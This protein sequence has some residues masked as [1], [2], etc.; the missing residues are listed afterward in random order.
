MKVLK[1]LGLVL[2]G[3]L[4]IVIVLGLIAPKDFRVERSIVIPTSNKEVIYKNISTWSDFLKW[5]PW[6]GKDPNQK[7]TYAGTEATVG[8]NYKWDGNKEVGSG[9]MTIT[10]M[11]P[12]ERVEMDLH[13]IRPFETTNKT[14]FTMSPEG[15]GYKVSWEMSG[16]SPFPFNVFGL[17]MNMDKMVGPDF[18]AGLQ[19]LKLKATE[20]AQKAVP[21]PAEAPADSSANPNKS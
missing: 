13:F 8:A 1:I 14:I 16:H 3:L 15:E 7:I 4:A 6:S 5:N 18:E 17:F 19:T 10:S 20:E 11:V 12:N 2:L 9:E 21:P